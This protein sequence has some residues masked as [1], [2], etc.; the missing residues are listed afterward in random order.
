MLPCATRSAGNHSVLRP[1][2]D[3]PCCCAP[4]LVLFVLQTRTALP[5]P[6]GTYTVAVNQASSCTP[7]P[8][9]ITTAA[10]KSTDPAQCDRAI[11]AGY[12]ATMLNGH[13]VPV[14]CAV[15]TYSSDGR[16]C[17]TCPDDL[18]TVGEG[19]TTSAECLAPP[20]WGYDANHSPKTYQC[21]GGSY[22]VSSTARK[23]LQAVALHRSAERTSC[24]T[25][26]LQP[27]GSATAL[28]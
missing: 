11:T 3:S 25:R 10:A 9:G 2:S 13:Q 14:K 24:A 19:A 8:D 23:Q 27:G 16:V 1:L 6:Q 18:T 5:C 20:G 7:C 22:K 17:N 15:G 28:V 21:P 12:I 26:Q 4:L